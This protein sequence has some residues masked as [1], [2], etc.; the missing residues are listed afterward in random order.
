M[1]RK[2]ELLKSGWLGKEM[3]SA[4]KE[5]AGWPEWKRRGLKVLTGETRDPKQVEVK[6]VAATKAASKGR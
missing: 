5:M 2:E 4:Q 1:A 6:R 3:E